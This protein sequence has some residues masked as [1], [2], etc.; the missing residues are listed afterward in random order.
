MTRARR[1]LVVLALALLAVAADAH[2]CLVAPRQRGLYLEQQEVD[3]PATSDVC[4]RNENLA[5]L[6][7]ADSPNGCAPRRRRVRPR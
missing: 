7:V 5:P 6:Q 4:K 3:A 1:A 2:L